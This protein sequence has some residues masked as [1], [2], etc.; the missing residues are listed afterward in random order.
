M[1]STDTTALVDLIYVLAFFLGGLGLGV[2][3]MVLSRLLAP[4]RTRTIGLKSLQAIECGV[5]PIGPTWIRYGVVYYLYALI[6]V[7]F[8]VDV[9]F[10]F[11]VAVVYNEAP[12]WLDLGEV[13]L[14]IGIL[15]LIIIYAWKK[16]VFTWKTR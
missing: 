3:P 1:N 12:G 6:F 8:S 14:F 7:A 13:L 10:L 16:D 9:L 5:D 4:K 15:A 2:I 11:P